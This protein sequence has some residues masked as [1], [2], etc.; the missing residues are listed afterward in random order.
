MLQYKKVNLAGRIL[1]GIVV[2][3]FLMSAAMKLMNHPEVVKGMDHTGIS[4]N[5]ILPLGILELVC[6]LVFLIPRTTVLGAILLTGY[7]G[8]A[9]LTHLRIG[10]VFYI[11][12]ILGVLI[13]AAI[14]LR[15]PRLRDLIPLRKK[16]HSF[17]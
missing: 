13:W 5:L 12:A 11:Q 7:L 8:G 6:V 9:I 17:L 1:T 2:V 15:D 3:P 14:F 16:Q 10:E 4:E